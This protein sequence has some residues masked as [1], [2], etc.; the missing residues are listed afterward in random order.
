M[1]FGR[2]TTVFTYVNDSDKPEKVSYKNARM[3]AVA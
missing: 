1:A 3:F 2:D